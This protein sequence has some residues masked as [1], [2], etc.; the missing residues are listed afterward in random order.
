M[1]K[2]RKARESGEDRLISRH[3]KPLARHPGALGLVDDAAVLSPPAGHELVLKTD[4][5]VGGIHFF[6]DDPPDTVARKALRVNLSDLA[7]KG[8]K[9]AGYLLSLIIPKGIDERWLKGISRGLAEDG[10]K[11]GCPLLGGDTDRTSGPITLSIAAFGTLP[12]GTMVLRSGARV[13]DH[14]VVTGTIGDAALGLKLRHDS[15]A[16][17]RWKLNPTMRR[18]LASRYLLPRPRNAL[19]KVLRRHASGGMDVSDG[20]VGDLGKLLRASGVGADIEVA[21]VPLSAAGRAAVKA[22]PKVV[23]IILTGGDDFEIV[24]TI[25]P[26]KLKA[27]VAAARRTGVPVTEIGRVTAGEGARFRDAWGRALVFKRTSFS[28]F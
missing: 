9:P 16:A 28:H 26:R 14:V 13:G 24:A 7:G 8:A 20:L 15:N 3:F 22:E 4:A 2:R 1:A 21:R 5:I 10:R 17:K 23:E 12:K 19:A 6:E 25:P 27:F 18:H 11:Y